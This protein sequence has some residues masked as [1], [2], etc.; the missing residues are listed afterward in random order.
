[1]K[2]SISYLNMK[3]QF[4]KLII[5]TALILFFS[6]SGFAQF[7]INT[8]PPLNGGS[9]SAGI[10]FNVTAHND[11]TIDTLF[12]SFSSTGNTEIWYSQNPISG[13]PTISTANGWVRLASA[14]V[15]K[16]ARGDGSISPIEH[17]LG[18]KMLKGQTFG[19]Y[20]DGSKGAPL[21]YTVL[22][23]ARPAP[24]SDGNITIE[25]GTNVGYGGAA[26]TPSTHPR[27]FNGGVKYTIVGGMNDA[28]VVSIDLPNTYCT[29]LRNVEAT[30]GN[31]G[32]NQ[33][34]SVDVHWEINSIAQT[35]FKYTQLLD[36]LNGSNPNTAK[37]TLG[38]HNFQGPTEIKVFTS[39]PNNMVDTSNYNDT[40]VLKTSPQFAG[41][42]S[43]NS[44][45][46]ASPTNFTSLS[47]MISAL[48]KHGLCGPTT[49]N[50]ANGTYNEVLH[51]AN[52]PGLSVNN[53]LVID[54][55][56]SSQTIVS[57]DGSIAFATLVFDG[58]RHVR[59]QNMTFEM[60]G[61]K[62]AA[63]IFKNASYDTLNNCVTR[64]DPTVKTSAVYNIS[65][66]NSITLNGTNAIVSN[67]IIQNNNIIG[68][69]RGVSSSGP[70]TNPNQN[71]KIYNNIVD[72]VHSYGFHFSYQNGLE[73]VGNSVDMLSSTSSSAT[74]L[75]VNYSSD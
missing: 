74:P 75:T 36:T 42:Y 3:D 14:S 16:N 64:T 2:Y 73:V 31:F 26:P 67:V 39:M 48:S 61:T 18:L 68:G 51:I 7:Q 6:L 8:V 72:S 47:S 52:I 11:L 5:S 49:I 24:F 37:I 12:A 57:Q 10:T 33:I 13:S 9:G 19:F 17:D 4:L 35:S 66:S 30:I 28:A 27:Q 34:D 23:P 53:N 46:P 60:T 54:G 20:I 29:G 15:S 1:M 71:N 38:Q 32:I 69:F 50:V 63:V 21:R 56:D 25:T 43:V 65:F 41:S 40:V 70:T 44:N 58:V 59:V 45:Q 62:G 55:G 22:S